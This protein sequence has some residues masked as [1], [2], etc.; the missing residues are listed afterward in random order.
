MRT[1]HFHKA[2]FGA[3]IP[4][5]APAVSMRFDGGERHDPVPPPTT[6][7][8]GGGTTTAGGAFAAFAAGGEA[9]FFG[10]AL[11]ARE[12]GRFARCPPPS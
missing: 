3:P 2:H 9:F 4:P 11:R 6:A 5:P 12:G 1:S 10:A 7:T 8:G